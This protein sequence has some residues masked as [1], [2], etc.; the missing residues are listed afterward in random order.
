MYPSDYIMTYQS[1]DDQDGA[2][3]I[4][5]LALGDDIKALAIGSAASCHLDGR[6]VGSRVARERINKET[7]SFG[8]LSRR[9]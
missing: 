1:A 9:D 5:V 8:G 4:I 7:L 6:Q 2:C 3:G